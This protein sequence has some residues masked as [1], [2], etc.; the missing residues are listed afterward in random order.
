M[1]VF[2]VITLVLVLFSCDDDKQLTTPQNNFSVEVNGHRWEGTTQ[3]NYYFNSKDSLTILGIVPQP[4]GVIGMGIKFEGAGEYL[5]TG[6]NCEYRSTVGH[7]V[8]IGEYR[9]DQNN[10]GKLVITEYD[11]ETKFIK[12][13][14]EM[15][16]KKIYANPDTVPDIL[17]FRKGTFEGKI[18]AQ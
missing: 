10:T 14:F 13:T 11:P 16:L 1:R 12:G 18:P 3:I 17:I 6:L 4:E 2:I 5:L 8:R 7:D 15:E 9:L